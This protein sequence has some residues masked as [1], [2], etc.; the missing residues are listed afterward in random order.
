MARV[1]DIPYSTQKAAAG[2][3]ATTF[4]NAGRRTT[5]DLTGLTLPAIAG[6]ASLGVGRLIYT[7]PAGAL[8]IV[9]SSISVALKQTQ[10]NI[11]ADTPDL[12][13][14]MVIA[15]GAVATLDGTATFEN[16][17]TGQT[18]NDCDGTVEATTVGTELVILPADSHGLFLNVADG[19]A[20]SGDAAVIVSGTVTVSWIP[21]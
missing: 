20:A 21:L 1:L 12:G 11:T 4:A 15:S 13:L 3:R 6:G 8:K 9:G 10:G 16:V 2:P 17:M 7:F 14:G 5:I 18:M 19:W